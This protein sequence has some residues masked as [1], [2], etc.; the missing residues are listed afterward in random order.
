MVGFDF[1]PVD[2]VDACVN[3]GVN[4]CCAGNCGVKT[5]S[6]EP[7]IQA[8]IAAIDTASCASLDLMSGGS[9]PT[10]CIGV[11]RSA[12]T[13]TA[14]AVR[15]RAASSAERVGQIVSD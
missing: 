15:V 4:T 12:L 13:S 6:T 2:A 9:L 14:P 11:V 1:H 5:V 8:C 3:A 10:I 7:E